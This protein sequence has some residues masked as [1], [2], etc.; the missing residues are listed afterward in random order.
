MHRM[1]PTKHCMDGYILVSVLLTPHCWF[2]YACA[3]TCH[4]MVTGSVVR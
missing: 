2:V 3:C 4:E 1:T